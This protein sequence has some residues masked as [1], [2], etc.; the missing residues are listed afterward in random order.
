MLAIEIESKI[1]KMYVLNY[2]GAN[3]LLN[4]EAT[5]S[6]VLTGKNFDFN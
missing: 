3:D 1:F 2:M 5:V 6:I 4:T